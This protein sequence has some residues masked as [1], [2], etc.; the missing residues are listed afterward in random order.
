MRNRVVIRREGVARD[1]EVFVGRRRTTHDLVVSFILHHNDYHM[2]YPATSSRVSSAGARTTARVAKGAL[3]NEVSYDPH[4]DEDGHQTN[5]DLS[6]FQFVNSNTDPS[7]IEVFLRSVRTRP[8]G[9]DDCP[10]HHTEADALPDDVGETQY[11]TP[12]GS[13]HVG[14]FLFPDILRW[15]RS[16]YDGT[17]H[18][19]VDHAVVLVRPRLSECVRV[20]GSAG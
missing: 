16:Y 4:D 5:D 7:D 3:R 2:S 19:G 9:G 11:V 15:L 18:V 10:S 6:G 8:L 14:G 1:E 13:A 20:G 12:L 17:L